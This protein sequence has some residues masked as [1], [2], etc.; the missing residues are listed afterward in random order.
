MEIGDRLGFPILVNRAASFLQ[1][2]FGIKS[3]RNKRDQ[4]RADKEMANRFHFGLR[5]LGI[6]AS[7]H[8]LFISSA[9]TD[10]HLAEILQASEDV[11]KKMRSIQ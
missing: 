5:A 6:M 2:H 8:P 10:A 9:H 4:L 1:I 3:I 11:L 7:Y